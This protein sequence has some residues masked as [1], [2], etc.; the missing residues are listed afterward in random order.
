MK[1]KIYRFL[2]E[3]WLEQ[4]RLQRE[5]LESAQADRID[6]PVIWISVTAAVT[7]TLLHYGSDWGRVL[8]DALLPA[9]AT[10]SFTR[11]VLW[12]VTQTLLYF[13][14]PWLT[15]RFV[16][17][18]PLSQFGLSFGGIGGS[19][20]MPLLMYLGMVPFILW[21]SD[22][23]PFQRMY[24]F[25]RP[26]MEESF[27]PR[28]IVWQLLYAVQFAA[29]EFFFR[30]YLIHGWKRRFGPYAV[31]A[32]MIPYCLIHFGKPLPETLGSIVAGVVLGLL[33]L[34][35]NSIWP[36]AALHIAVAWTM[37]AAV[38]RASI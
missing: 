11:Q 13:L 21:F 27:W 28:M 35:T 30:G 8:Y 18:R 37:D 29:L 26:E 12:A 34:K 23:P 15:I 1:Q 7:M 3:P 10:G 16:L 20:W 17:R 31:F 19:L 24:P 4:Q 33:S 6:W 25:Y 22:S 2:T 32:A 36:G 5:F 9:A 38:L 14:V